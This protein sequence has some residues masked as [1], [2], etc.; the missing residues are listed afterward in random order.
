MSDGGDFSPLASDE[1]GGLETGV[2]G[3]SPGGRIASGDAVAAFAPSVASVVSVD[4]FV[5]GDGRAPFFLS[6]SVAASL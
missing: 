2:E 5:T 3:C 4:A 1:G 6:S